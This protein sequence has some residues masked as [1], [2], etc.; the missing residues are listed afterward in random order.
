MHV[1]VKH[2]KGM[3]FEGRG[4]SGGTTH[5]AAPEAGGPSP[6]ELLLMGAA[7]C[8]G[9]DVV[10]MLQKMRLDYKSFEISVEGTRAEDFPRVFTEIHLTYKFQGDNLPENKVRRA[11]ELSLDKYCSAINTLNKTAKVTYSLEIV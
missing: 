3:V 7:G 11:I 4:E 8:S 9:I 6:M 1:T 5:I 2:V 10:E